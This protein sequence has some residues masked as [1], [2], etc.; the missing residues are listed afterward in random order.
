MVAHTQLMGVRVGHR[1]FFGVLAIAG[2]NLFSCGTDSQVTVQSVG[3][4]W[5][6]LPNPPE[7]T[8]SP[9]LEAEGGAVMVFGGHVL[10]GETTELVDHGFYLAPGDSAWDTVPGPGTDV[11]T[12]S[13]IVYAHETWVLAGTRCAEGEREVDCP[14][15]GAGFYVSADPSDPTAGWVDVQ[16][17]ESEGSPRLL[18]LVNG[19]PTYKVFRPDGTSVIWSFEVSSAK[20]AVWP[21]PPGNDH[22]TCAISTGL[23]SLSFQYRESTTGEVFDEDPSL[24]EAIRLPADGV[25]SPS[26]ALILAPDQEWTTVAPPV[27]DWE[28]PV[29]FGLVCTAN[30]A[31]VLGTDAAWLWSSGRSTVLPRPRGVDQALT[32]MVAGQLFDDQAIYLWND[33]EGVSLAPEGTELMSFSAPPVVTQLTAQDEVGIVIYFD[34]TEPEWTHETRIYRLQDGDDLAPSAQK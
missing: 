13:S 29:T 32:S 8:I 33:G 27:S 14:P 3:E 20:W 6:A 11:L 15:A 25:L 5:E 19:D 2:I 12:G 1:W 26:L 24:R 17:P 16:P 18:G 7:V 28:D 34:A 22:A 21:T 23:V 10:R 4:E 9:A 31:L 30:A